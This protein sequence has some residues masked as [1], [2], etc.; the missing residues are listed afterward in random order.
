MSTVG[1]RWDADPVR[2]SQACLFVWLLRCSFWI[3]FLL[4]AARRIPS[5]GSSPFSQVSTNGSMK[6]WGDSEK[7]SRSKPKEARDALTT[8]PKY[9]QA[10]AFEGHCPPTGFR[11]ILASLWPVTPEEF[12]RLSDLV[13][14]SQKTLRGWNVCNPVIPGL[15]RQAEVGIK[16]RRP[17]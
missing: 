6:G 12:L 14:S 15:E 3:N 10:F 9:L 11:I 2:C 7:S 16:S 8:L 1:P 5:R 4:K 17:S 13:F